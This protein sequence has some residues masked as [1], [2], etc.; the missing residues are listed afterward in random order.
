[1]SYEQFEASHI[2]Q[3]CLNLVQL[4]TERHLLKICLVYLIL[5]A[6]A[7]SVLMNGTLTT[8]HLE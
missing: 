4:K 5:M 6:V 7:K 8:V 3:A 2:L 1:M